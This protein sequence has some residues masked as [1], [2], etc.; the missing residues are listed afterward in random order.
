[1]K[2]IYR[3]SILLCLL[4]SVM[5]SFAQKK[6]GDGNARSEYVVLASQSVQKDAA[7]M[8]VVDALKK[9]HNAEV[10]FY[11]KAPRENLADL[12]RVRPRYVAIVEKPENLGRDY[13][14]DM[15][16]VSREVDGDIFADF[17]WGIITGYDAEAA[18][19]MVNNSTEPLL[20]KDAVATIMEL[21]SAKWF[22]NYAWVDDHN[23]GLWGEKKGRDAKIQTAQIDPKTVLKKFTDI[24]AEYNPDLVVTAAHAT[25]RN[26]EMPYSLG[27]IMAKDGKLYARDHFAN[28]TWDLKESGKRKVY[29]AVGNC[30][31][32]NVN[33]TKESM[34]IAWMNSGNAATMIGYVVTTWHGRNGWG[35]LKYWVTNPGRYTLAEAIYMNQQDFL[36][37]QNEWYP[38]LIKENYNFDGN[39]F[40]I[41]GQKIANAIKGQPTQDQIG[42]WHDRDVLAYYGD[43]KWEVRLQEV[44][45]ETDFTVTSKVKGK[46]CIIT[47]NTKENFS[48]ERMK[49]DKF[50]QEHVLDLPFSYFFPTRLNNPRLAAGQDW[51]A[52]VDENFLII[53]NPEFKPNSTYEIVLD[54]D[55]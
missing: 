47:I 14:I 1:M 28:T 18:M 44:P 13:V 50:K 35:G 27:N 33:N 42:F 5:P 21:N 3:V 29:F 40:Q 36:Y 53:Y 22:D 11:E 55:K 10:F 20:V 30:L 15:H 32:G 19:K 37:Q 45:G 51:K 54:I 26:L 6:K 48:L 52:A 12:Q 2:Q 38:S 17:L 4:V 8:Q 16:H 7:W 41:A 39:E 9:K 46:K 24:Y 31:I 43:P 34:A 49:G 23:R 25:E